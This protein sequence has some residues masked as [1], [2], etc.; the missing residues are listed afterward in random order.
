MTGADIL[1]RLIRISKALERDNLV[2][3]GVEFRVF[4]EEWSDLIRT[5]HYYGGGP[6]EF[7]A[8]SICYLGITIRNP[9]L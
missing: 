6:I 2:P 9:D 1:N 3:L 7:D 4:R 8:R 5:L